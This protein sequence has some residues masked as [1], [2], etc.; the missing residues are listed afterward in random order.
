MRFGW[1]Y[2][3]FNRHLGEWA[4]ELHGNRGL[5]KALVHSWG[6]FDRYAPVMWPITGRIEPSRRDAARQR[7]G[8]GIRQP[9]AIPGLGQL[10]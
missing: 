6:T 9:R 3:Y 10:Q 2:Y 8:F 1:L 4:L 5:K 7:G